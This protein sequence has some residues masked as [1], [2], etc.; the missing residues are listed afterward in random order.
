[1]PQR[2]TSRSRIRARAAGG[3]V[4]VDAITC[5]ILRI[6]QKWCQR[7]PAGARG[8]R[9]GVDH[10]T[11]EVDEWDHLFEVIALDKD[12]AGHHMKPRRGGRPGPAPQLSAANRAPSPARVAGRDHAALAH[13]FTPYRSRL[14]LTPRLLTPIAVRQ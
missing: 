6:R 2:R 12:G 14:A 13:P 5:I 9:D 3:C 7:R 1:M 8:R 4:V 11:G 10:Q